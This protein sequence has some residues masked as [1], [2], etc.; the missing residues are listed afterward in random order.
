M[1]DEALEKGG[2]VKKWVPPAAASARTSYLRQEH[3]ENSIDE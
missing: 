2:D 3:V 1:Y